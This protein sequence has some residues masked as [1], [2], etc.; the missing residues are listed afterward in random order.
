[1]RVQNLFFCMLTVFVLASCK[2]N[3][4]RSEKNEKAESATTASVIKEKPKDVKT[5]EGM[6]WI[7]GGK[8]IQGARP[9]D[10]MALPH[11][12]P[13]H[14]VMVDGFFM[15]KTEV[16]NADFK[17]FVEATGYVTVAERKLDWEEIKKQLPP[18]TPKP[19]DSILQPGSLVFKKTKESVPNLY[20]YS[21][22]WEWKIGANWRH[23]YGPDSSIEGKENYPVVHVAYED[24]QAYCEWAGRR[25][26][27]EAEW[28]YAAR[29]GQPNARFTWGDDETKLSEKAN[30]WEGEFP[31]SNTKAD[32]FEGVAP[33]KSF[34][35]NPYGL[36]DMAGNV[37]EFT[38][39]WYNVNYYSE[40]KSQG[41]VKDPQGPD[42]AYNP[43]NPRIEEKV[44][45][46]GS[47]LCNA[48]YCASFR[49]SARMANSLD[50]SH[51]HLGFRT[52]ASPGMIKGS[53]KN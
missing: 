30:T 21:Q 29:G 41:L 12:K 43:N 19:A 16:T 39:D 23:P 47:F 7:P 3:N 45:K 10:D 1:M 34:P 6:V 5:P 46:G 32:G 2:E 15:D 33:V 11:E 52:V 49:I 38:Q 44:I 9:G 20:D 8:F 24:A 4:D 53:D 42:S 50:S 22:W 28:E 17:K 31:T 51:E 40:L 26:P 14:E 36:F 35:E 18:G 48:S 37:W 27:T 13:A 25:L